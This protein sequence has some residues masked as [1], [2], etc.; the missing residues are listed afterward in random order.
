[1]DILYKCI[2]GSQAY[3]TST[4]T[5]DIDYKGVYIQSLNEI[6]S[7]NKYQEQVSFNKDECYYE[8]KRFI[9][10]IGVANPTIL[11][12]LFTDP[13]Y[14]IYK[15]PI[16]D[17]ILNNKHKFLTKKCKDT[18]AGYAMTQIKKAKGLN[19]KQ[20]W[21]TSKIIRRDPLNFTVVHEDGKTIDIKKWL[22]KNNYKQENCG[23]VNLDYMH[24]CYALYYSDVPGF[25]KGIIGSDSNEL[26]YSSVPK[27]EKPE[28][29]IYFNKDGYSMH[30]A[31]Y[32]E[33]EEWLKCRNEQ[34]YVDV[35]NHNQKID[36]KNLMHCVRLIDIAT[37]IAT[38]NTIIVKRPNSVGEKVIKEMYYKYIFKEVD[39][40]KYNKDLEDIVI[41]D[42]DGTLCLLNGRNP[43]DTAKCEND[44][45]NEPVY[46][47]IKNKK[48]IFIT[49]RDEKYRKQTESFLKKYSINYEYL[50]MREDNNK[51]KDFLFKERIYNDNI[52]NKFNVEFIL[53]DRNQVVQMWRKLGLTVF[54]VADGDF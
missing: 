41:C 17:I 26:R 11:E 6:L 33:Y 9:E 54:Q 25:Y 35:K 46:N 40:I 31:D 1:M 27:G 5:S 4:P 24:N 14:I 20:N 47:I 8:I 30:C 52:K 38:D 19:K 51:E 21:E 44:L 29:V 36:G 42:L 37:E 16:F 50:F 2:V 53:E 45:I 28:C 39:P 49:G 12:L 15:N 23:L 34:R 32:R 18:F 13:K 10:L 22:E 48:A 43:F 3:G 7:I